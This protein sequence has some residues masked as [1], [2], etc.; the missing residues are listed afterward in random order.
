MVTAVNFAYFKVLRTC[1]QVRTNILSRDLSHRRC[2]KGLVET[3]DT[4]RKEVS[5]LAVSPKYHAG[6]QV[7]AVGRAAV[8]L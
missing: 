8:Q 4:S 3:H 6:A 5:H 7:F 2:R 1:Y